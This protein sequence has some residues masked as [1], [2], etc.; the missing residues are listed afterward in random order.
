MDMTSHDT[1]HVPFPQPETSRSLKP[2]AADPSQTER[3]HSQ[4][5]A[6]RG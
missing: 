3:E 6:L 5:R 2:L 1:L 4:A